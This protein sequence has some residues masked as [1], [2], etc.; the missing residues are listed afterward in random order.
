M[1]G[2]SFI[3][4]SVF[5]ENTHKISHVIGVSGNRFHLRVLSFLEHFNFFVYFSFLFVQTVGR[6]SHSTGK[7]HQGLLEI[8]ERR[9]LSGEL[10]VGFFVFL[11]FCMR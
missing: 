3:R 8:A 5:F 10:F 1:L 2:R 11:G 6:D 9:E 7:G 4:G